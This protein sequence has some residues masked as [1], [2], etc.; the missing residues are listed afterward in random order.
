[1]LPELGVGQVGETGVVAQARDEVGE[2]LLV[3]VV[4][5]VLVGVAIGCLGAL[6]RLGPRL[7]IGGVGLGA[8]RAAGVR[9]LVEAE[10]GAGRLAGGLGELA[11]QRDG[12]ADGAGEAVEAGRLARGGAGCCGLV[13]GLVL[14]RV[15][16]AAGSA[17]A[18]RWTA[19]ARSV[20]MAM[21]L[22]RT[23]R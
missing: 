2:G 15:W 6:A 10:L 12:A 16:G 11:G 5:E 21:S 7:G 20:P 3:E 9:A 13:L 19:S 1:M 18:W 17:R 14:G 8:V 23:W 4:V 22:C